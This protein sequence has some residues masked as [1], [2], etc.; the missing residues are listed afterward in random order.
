M[1]QGPRPGAP[2]TLKDIAR[3]TGY[4]VNTVSRALRDKDDIA[5][6]TRAKI[7]A[8]A[9]EMGHINNTLAS[10]LRL[11]F[12]NTI[13]VILGDVANPHFAIMMGEIERRARE[14][15]Y[16]SFLLNTNEDEDQERAAI[17]TALNKKVDGI[18]LCPAQHSTENVRFLQRTGVPFVLMGRRFP[19]LDTDDV[20]CDDEQGGYLAGKY[21]LDLG[22]R[23]ILMLHGPDYISSARE[24]LD[25]YRRALREAGVAGDPALI[26]PVPVVNRVSG[27]LFGC[28]DGGGYTAVLAF[29]DLLAWGAWQHLRQR[30]VRVP[31][32]CSVVGFDHIESRLALPFA[33]TTV[34]ASKGR[35]SAAAVDL[36]TERIRLGG[37]PSRHVVLDTNI[38]VGETTAPPPIP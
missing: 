21:L 26:R 20:V 34:S 27:D 25:G 1:A 30:G 8:V 36:L 32:D 11:G 23:R 37:G 7:Q 14:L 18:I 15:G 19:D 35:M 16:A 10:A 4:S 17:R 24:R 31:E 22:H 5:P 33:L 29:S 38:V 13:A 3:R 12:T 2:V 6:A 9:A 28:L